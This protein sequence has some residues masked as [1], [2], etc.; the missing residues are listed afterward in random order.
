MRKKPACSVIAIEE[1]YWD[2]ELSATYT[3]IGRATQAEEQVRRLRD[4]GELRIREMDEGGIDIQVLSHGSPSTQE[5]TGPDGIALTKRVS[6]RLAS[7]SIR[8]MRSARVAER[9][10]LALRARSAKAAVM[11]R[12]KW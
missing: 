10:K 7:R 12:L 9:E 2:E 8:A 3:G 1:H 5:L 4:L 11:A 6:S